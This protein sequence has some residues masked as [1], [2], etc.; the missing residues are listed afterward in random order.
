MKKRRE[1]L[2]KFM[3]ENFDLNKFQIDWED[4]FIVSLIDING[5]QLDLI[6]YDNETIC[7]YID[8]SKFLTYRLFPDLEGNYCFRVI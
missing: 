5:V 1:L 6:C 8:G 3:N 4:N 7:S 2:E